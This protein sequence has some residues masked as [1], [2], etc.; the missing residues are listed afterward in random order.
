MSVSTHKH[1]LFIITKIITIVDNTVS[2]SF[3]F[4]VPSSLTRRLGMSVRHVLAGTRYISGVGKKSWTATC[5]P[6]SSDQS[7]IK[8]G[9]L[10]GGE[11]GGVGPELNPSLVAWRRRLIFIATWC[12]FYAHKSLLWFTEMDQSSWFTFLYMYV[13]AGGT[14]EAKEKRTNEVCVKVKVLDREPKL[15][16]ATPVQMGAPAV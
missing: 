1:S 16:S 15:H 2:Q 5:N 11:G 10:V 6:I 4:C 12:R 13:T 7:Q 9:A 3:F 8:W 14:K